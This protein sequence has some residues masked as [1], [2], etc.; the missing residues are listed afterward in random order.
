[1]NE[2]RLAWHFLRR[3]LENDLVSPE[4]DRREVLSLACAVMVSSGLFLTTALAL[5]YLFAPFPSPGRT[6]MAAVDDRF[7]YCSL[8]MLVM[9][10]VAV[11]CWHGLALDS[12]DKAILGALPI[13]HSSVVKAKATAI[14]ILLGVFAFAVNVIPSV[15]HPVLATARLPMTP[16]GVLH[17]M[18]VHAAVSLAAGAL[19]FLCV[20]TLRELLL[21]ALGTREFERVSSVAQASL[22]IVLV[23]AVLLVPGLSPQLVRRGLRADSLVRYGL[24]PLW[25]VGLQEVLAGN[26]VEALPRGELPA[27]LFAAEARATRQYRS[28]REQFETL[29]GFA[30][31]ALAGIAL[32]ATGGFVWNCRHFWSFSD[33]RRAPGSRLKLAANRLAK[34]L[35]VTSPGSAAG[36]FFTL[37]CLFRSVTHRQIIALGAALALA[38]IA[39]GSRDVA[40]TRDV[41]PPPV[42][43]LQIQSI[44]IAILLAGLRHAVRVPA[45]LRATWILQLCWSGD[46]RP[47]L[48][49]VKRAALVGLCI[50]SVLL[51]FPIGA[52]TMG[53]PRGIVHA[54]VGVL[55]GSVL[56][57]FLF[58]GYRKVPF[59]C[60]YVPS[61]DLR[62]VGVLVVVGIWLTSHAFAWVEVLGLRT[63]STAAVLIGALS[64]VRIALGVLGRRVNGGG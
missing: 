40:F 61:G 41:R 37:Q 17:V 50:P 27:P 44:A 42:Y 16:L 1:M 45:E 26:V 11:V 8:S 55:F 22:V 25:F 35:L 13:R 20:L 39:A 46:P 59:G 24:P 4:A 48:T 54:V 34:R 38:V 63:P 52:Y 58:W 19:G 32:L 9:A 23:L 12:R 60:P 36:F 6:A 43:V 15:L 53:V 51:L 62:V 29:S 7:L 2:R 10:L 5:K 28:H 18:A 49:G 30:G 31:L 47:F 14:L 64:L 21:A 33:Q 3:F 56:L 57:E